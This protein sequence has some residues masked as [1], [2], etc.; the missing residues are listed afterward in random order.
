MSD[1]RSSDDDVDEDQRGFLFQD[2]MVVKNHELGLKVQIQ[3]RFLKIVDGA[4]FVNLDVYKSRGISQMMTCR[5]PKIIFTERRGPNALQAAQ[6]VLNEMRQ[7]RDLTFREEVQSAAGNDGS[8]FVGC[9]VPKSKRLRVHAMAHAE[10][11]VFIMPGIPNVVEPCSC[12]CLRN[13][14]KRQNRH[15]QLLVEIDS[16]ILEY[17]A[18][19]VAHNFEVERN[20]DVEIDDAFVSNVEVFQPSTPDHDLEA[21]MAKSTSVDGQQDPPPTVGSTVA[22]AN[23]QMTLFQAFARAA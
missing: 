17:I 18:K 4:R 21:T 20:T 3:P 5:L 10:T 14:S 12:T 11:I 7:R 13:T 6:R 23:K 22:A 1:H 2:A 9:I 19:S 15:S 16:A 8:K